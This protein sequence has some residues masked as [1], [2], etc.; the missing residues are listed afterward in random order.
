M[1]IQSSTAATHKIAP[2][3]SRNYMHQLQELV[4]KVQ[5]VL[6]RLSDKTR[7]QSD[8]QETQY[9]VYS[10]KSARTQEKQGFAAPLISGAALAVAGLASAASENLQYGMK[11]FSDHLPTLSN[12]YTAKL[13]ADGTRSQN[14]VQLLQTKLQ[15]SQ[16]EAGNHQTL[17]QMLEGVLS[18]AQRAFTSMGH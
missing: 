6:N 11:A 17:Q 9:R 2:A 10:E 15:E 3:V 13:T 7:S 12:F 14:M 4:L 8:K 1:T 18:A 16:G 5:L